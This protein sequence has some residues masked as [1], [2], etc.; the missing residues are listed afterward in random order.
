MKRIVVISELIIIIAVLKKSTGHVPTTKADSAFS[1][2]Y[3]A[4][5]LLVVM[6]N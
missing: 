3:I 6:A 2:E 4:S 1:S 5:R